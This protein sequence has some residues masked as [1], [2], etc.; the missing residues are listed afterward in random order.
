MRL[1]I[2]GAHSIPKSVLATYFITN[3]SL[4]K[5]PKQSMRNRAKETTPNLPITAT[6]LP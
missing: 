2:W 1:K 5:I 4:I 6:T 3:I